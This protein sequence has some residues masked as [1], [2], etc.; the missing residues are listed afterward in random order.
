M[1]SLNLSRRTNL[2]LARKLDHE[3][4]FSLEEV[5]SLD[6]L[7]LYEQD[8]VASIPLQGAESLFLKRCVIGD[9]ST[10]ARASAAVSINVWY[11]DLRSIDF[12]RSLE[13]VWK[14]DV[15]G[16]RVR[17]LSPLLSVPELDLVSVAGNPLDEVSYGETVPAL[18]AKGVFFAGEAGLPAEREWRMMQWFDERGLEI[19]CMDF[20]RGRP[21]SFVPGLTGGKLVALS[22]DQIKRLCDSSEGWSTETFFTAMT[23]LE[24]KE[25]YRE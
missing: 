16:C 12:C 6:T 4:P 22:P 1:M 25:G 8:N 13:E 14:V 15:R 5:A 23:E 11:S 21:E 20:N 9:S 2:S 3:P 24:N 18:K 17:D 10:I 7:Q 19:S